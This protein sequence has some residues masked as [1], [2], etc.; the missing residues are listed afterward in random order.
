MDWLAH[1]AAAPGKQEE[2]R[3]KALRK[4]SRLALFVAQAASGGEPVIDPLPQDRR[5]EHVDWQ[6]WPFN[7]YYQAFLL[8]QQWLWNATTGVRGVTRHHEHVVTFM[9]RQWLDIFSPSNFLATNPEVLQKTLTSGGTNLLQGMA[10][11][12]DDVLRLAANRPPVG[13]EDY[14]VGQNLA[15]TPGKVIFRNRLMEL[16][17]YAPQTDRVRPEPV[18]IVPSWIMKYYILDLAPGR[19]LVQYLV[20]NGHTVFIISWKNPG[21]EDRD[22]GMDAYQRDGV[23]T[24][25]D[26]VSTVCGKKI[27]ALGYCLGGTILAIAA[28]MLARAGDERL[29]TVTLLASELDF[30]E[31]GELS[32]FIDESQLAFLEDIMWTRGYLDGK[33]MAGAFTLLNS[34]D[35]VW[36][37][38]VHDYLMG[39]RAPVT[40]LMAWNADATRMPYRM[41]S[42]YLQHLYLE[43]DLAEGRYIVDG[44]PVALTDIRAPLFVVGT[45]RDHVSPWRSVYQVHL[46]TDTEVTFLLT[47]GGHN[48][49]VVN[50][51][52]NGFPG[53]SYQVSTR[54]D[55]SRYIDPDSWAA[56]TPTHEGSWWPEFLSW[57]NAHCGAETQPPGIG[58]PQSG[59]VPIFDAPGE[60]VLLS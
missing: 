20:E 43:N 14:Q 18:L 4:L 7:L 42:E 47:S 53:R 35:L 6:Q 51:P 50:P 3:E 13:V 11:W 30:S 22:I 40:D 46:L 56:N 38:M 32:L 39:E 59:L 52:G 37:R 45:Q 24:A 34:K 54:P 57:L 27:N 44:R 1:L 10:N 26:T 5:F 25:I 33:E 28:A 49:G 21:P 8:A 2:L 31:P 41:H 19:S 23:L 58:A 36:S 12:W 29:N 48:V 15:L 17:Q 55:Q 16:I 60:Y 9:A